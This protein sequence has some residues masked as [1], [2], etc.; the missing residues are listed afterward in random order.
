LDL[1]FDFGG[2]SS[3]FGDFEIVEVLEIE[4]EF[5]IGV[6]ISGEAKG[7]FGG[8]AAAFVDDFTDARGGDTELK[9]E[10]VDGQME[11]LH[12]V[13]AEDF[14]GMNW[15][16]QF[17]GDGFWFGHLFRPFLVIVNEFDLVA[18]SIAPNETDSEL[19]VYANGVLS[20]TIAFQSFELVSRRGSENSQFGCGMKLQQFPQRNSFYGTKAFAAV[21]LKERFGFGRAEAQNHMCRVLRMALYVKRDTLRQ[22]TQ[23][24]ACVI[25]AI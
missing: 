15:R 7:G 22:G 24:E 20:F 2:F 9:S 3:A 11:R 14:A 16:H 4:P 17:C 1:T 8:D 19:I 25:G 10:L 21:V 12:E 23:A 5:R 13:L 6:E 18:I